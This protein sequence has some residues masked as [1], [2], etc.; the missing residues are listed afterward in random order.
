MRTPL[1]ITLG[2]NAVNLG[3]DTALILGL[4]WGVR[5][6]ATATTTAE[7]LAAAAYLA[8]LFQRREALGGLHPRLVLGERLA[9]VAEELVPFVKAGG[10]MLMRTALL[11]GTK[12]LA[13]ATAARCACAA[14]LVP[15]V[16]VSGGRLFLLLP[17]AACVIAALPLAPRTLSAMLRAFPPP[18]C[19]PDRLPAPLPQ[20]AG[21][22][23]CP[24]RRTKWCPSCG[25]SPPSCWT[26]WPLRGRPW[27]P[28]RC[29]ARGCASGAGS[30]VVWGQ[31]GTAARLSPPQ[32]GAAWQW[33]GAHAVPLALLTLNFLPARL[34][35]CLPA[36]PPPT[37]LLWCS[38]ARETCARRGQWATACWGWALAA[39][40][41]W[42]QPSGWRNL[43]S[44]ASLAA[45]QVR[46]LGCRARHLPRKHLAWRCLGW[47]AF[48]LPTAWLPLLSSSHLMCPL[49]FSSVL[50][51]PAADVEAAVREILP[52][53]VAM[54]PINAAV[55]VFDGIVTGAADFR[56]MA[57]A[58]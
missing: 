18:P 3:L 21:W 13:S 27:W 8:M 35:V 23:W 14:L 9:A 40:W 24:L 55:Y 17:T 19:L 2:A 11:L 50:T 32:P 36:W 16:W 49:S 28:C 58:C 51:P 38:W 7:W 47:V 4:G 26:L 42:Q 22:V 46:S 1:A 44:Q 5:G 53:A 31:A 33:A 20:S 45:M 34:P 12:T 10:A 56:F 43:S 48:S 25:C 57:G 15:F 52:I 29:A 54:L 41:P 6:A 30:V 37:A 39:A